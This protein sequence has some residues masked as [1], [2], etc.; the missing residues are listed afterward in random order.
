MTEEAGEHIPW[1]QLTTER[2]DVMT[3]KAVA[4]LSR[5]GRIPYPANP[6]GLTTAGDIAAAARV[7]ID[8]CEQSKATTCATMA[9]G[10]ILVIALMRSGLERTS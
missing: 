9:R 10:M 8:A 3:S 4:M 6:V 1:A 2:R 5:F 7:P